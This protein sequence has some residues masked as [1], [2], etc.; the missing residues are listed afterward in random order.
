MRYVKLHDAATLLGVSRHDISVLIAESKLSWKLDSDRSMLIQVPE[1][2][3]E[4]RKCDISPIGFTIDAAAK[5]LGVSRTTISK[6]MKQGT[7]VANRLHGTT[8]ITPESVSAEKA[9][10]AAHARKTDQEDFE[11]EPRKVKSK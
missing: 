3:D 6:L 5:E 9:R 4:F 1:D 10:R 8:R 7:L 11:A 2:R